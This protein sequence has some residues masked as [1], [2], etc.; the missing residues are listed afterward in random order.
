MRDFRDA[1]AM[2]QTLRQALKAKSVSLSHSE[3]LE[4]VARTLGFRGWN[5]LAAKIESERQPAVSATKIEMPTA[6]KKRAGALPTIPLRD[7]V[8]F[9]Q[10]VFPIFV[11]R[12]K[13]KLAVAQALSAEK[14]VF[15]ITQIRAR[16]DDPSIER[17][18]RVGVTASVVHQQ[19]LHNGTLKIIVQTL[20]RASVKRFVEGE[21]LAAQIT[22]LDERRGDDPD[23]A[24]LSRTVLEAYQAYTNLNLASPPQHLTGLPHIHEAAVLADAI[25]HLLSITI[26]QRQELLETCDVVE[27]LEKLLTLMKVDQKTA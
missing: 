3:S 21:F 9:P 12:D 6:Q 7:L 17:L 10:M 4:I 18:Y 23:A 15:G 19:L 24:R 27:R 14:V 16:D 5:V 22:P 11:G 25:A 2:A 8:L 26:D 13:T 20:Q 1:K